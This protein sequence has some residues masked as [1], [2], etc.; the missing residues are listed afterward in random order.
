MNY[1]T[2]GR[3]GFRVSRIGLGGGGKSR[4]G[5]LSGRSESESIAVVRRALELGVNFIDTAE[6]YRTEEI[7]GK[8]LRGH[9]RAELVISSKKSMR[10][11]HP[12]TPGELRAGLEGSLS[13]LETD[14]LDVY[15]LHGLAIDRY[16][17]ALSVLVPEML[18]LKDEG[19]IR[20]IGVTEIFDLDRSHRMLQR[21]CR[22]DCW[23]VMMVGF[24]MLNQSAR[25]RVI[26]AAI[27]KDIGVL[28]MFAVR[29]AMSKPAK[30]RGIVR[31][32]LESGQLRGDE[33]DSNDPLGFV[34]QESGSPSLMDAAYRFCR[35]E[36]GMHVILSGTGDV[37][38]M[39]ENIASFE[40]PPL[41]VE[42]RE[43]VVRMFAGL[44]TVSGQ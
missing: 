3:T 22:D 28:C 44:D 16:D 36:P 14:Y 25:E 26:D 2:L 30:L 38:H 15:H 42:V 24:N 29:D 31:E 35:D 11:D 21:A 4:L 12:V 19:K 39:E 33:I 37:S 23:E 17:H 10:Q 34:L 40:R 9:R 18:K 20:A 13:R 32:L 7:I 27:R 5:R 41:P 1:T 43:R 6:A 8:A